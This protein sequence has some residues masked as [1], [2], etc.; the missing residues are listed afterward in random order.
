MKIISVVLLAATVALNPAL[1][2]AQTINTVETVQAPAPGGHYSQGAV[3][4]GFVSR[5]GPTVHQA[6]R[7]PRNSGKH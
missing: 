2:A 7:R 3:A 5:F 4:D 6:R 1:A